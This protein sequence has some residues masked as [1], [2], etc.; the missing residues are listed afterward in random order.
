MSLLT[1][2]INTTSTA[3][4][5]SLLL[6]PL[7]LVVSLLISLETISLFLFEVDAFKLLGLPN[8]STC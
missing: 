4:F 8:P 7:C 5:H 2:N 6:H 1:P 3:P